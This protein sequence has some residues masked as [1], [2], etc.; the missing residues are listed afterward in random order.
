MGTPASTPST[1]QKIG[2]AAVYALL[3][4]V[5]AIQL[6]GM[7]ATVEGWVALGGTVIVAFWGKFSSSRT[8]IS[9]NFNG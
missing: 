9:A 1:L 3:A 8:V 4:G 7:P 5:G 6:G 2:V